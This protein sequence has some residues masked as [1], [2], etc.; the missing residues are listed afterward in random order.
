[1]YKLTI[2]TGPNKGKVY[3]LEKGEHIIGRAQDVTVS[4]VS[5][6]VS[7]RH[8]VITV[9][10]LGVSI[11]DLG[12]S[13]GTFVNGML[14]KEK[15]LN[16][17]DR[18]SVGEYIFEITKLSQTVV[19]NLQAKKNNVIPI[20]GVSTLQVQLPTG[21]LNNLEQAS[22]SI[23]EEPKNLKEKI[24]FY[25]EE[26]VINFLYRLNLKVEWK[27]IYTY[28]FIVFVAGVAVASVYPVLSR[29]KEKLQ[30]EARER[31]FLIARQMVEKNTAALFEKAESKLDISFAEKDP[32]VV[33]AYIID[34]E[35]RIMAPARLLNQFLSD[36][37]EAAF[38]AQVRNIFYENETKEQLSKRVSGRVF[39][40]VPLRV[41]NQLQGKNVTVAL[42]VVSY[43]EGM[44]LFDA[45]TE[46]L[47]Y[48]QALILA[49]LLG[50]IA[51]YSI[52]KITFK[53]IEHLNEEADLVLKGQA[54][55]INQKYQMSEIKPLIDLMNS[56]L[57]RVQGLQNG[58]AGS[59]AN[60]V[61][62]SVLQQ[63]LQSMAANLLGVGVLFIDSYKKIQFLNSEME[64]ITGI[65][66]AVAAGD[67]LSNVA[68]DASLGAFIEDLTSRAVVGGEA[69]VEDY[70]FSGKSYKVNCLAFG[71]GGQAQFYMITAVKA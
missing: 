27:V 19:Q 29:T 10:D 28:I 63:S 50:V 20:R 18:I 47:A 13:N 38:S 8:C 23:K 39:V 40:S 22:S 4:L 66:Q 58:S 70:E 65:R 15:K 7:K 57:T 52:Y 48:I 5:Q 17:G 62:L 56:L 11:R 33:S 21:V 43:N 2:L 54:Q 68:R 12:S 1:V 49:A 53:P 55:A 60:S 6:N 37:D 46:S 30:N 26:Y 34:M 31:A 24:I 32:G 3:P 41:F 64:E 69:I 59:D 67:E 35:G 44:L 61:S 71:G 45:G 9:S 51:Y 14:V 42:A 16:S 25:F 36:N